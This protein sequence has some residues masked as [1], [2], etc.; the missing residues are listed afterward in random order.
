MLQEQA[1]AYLNV[2]IAVEGDVLISRFS[3]FSR[4]HKERSDLSQLL[5][6]MLVKFNLIDRH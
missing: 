1:I 4:P 2:D 3:N 5:C 6:S